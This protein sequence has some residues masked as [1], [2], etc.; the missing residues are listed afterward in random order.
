MTPAAAS[1]AIPERWRI[2]RSVRYQRLGADELDAF[3]AGPVDQLLRERLLD[4]LRRRRFLNGR[5]FLRCSQIRHALPFAGTQPA[6]QATGLTP[7]IGQS[8]GSER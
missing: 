4:R 3:A 2:T 5:R 8:L 6:S 7:L 1:G